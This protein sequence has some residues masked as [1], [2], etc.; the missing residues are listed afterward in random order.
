MENNLPDKIR[1][2]REKKGLN[3]S[4]LAHLVGVSPS[5]IGQ[6]EKGDNN[7]K[8]EV[9]LKLNKVL[10]YDFINDRPLN[11][12]N[13]HETEYRATV[14]KSVSV[15][16]Y[17]IEFDAGIL[18][19]LVEKGENN[20]PVGYLNIPEVSGCDAII[21]AKGDSMAPRIN[22]GDWV[23]VKRMLNWTDWL[24]VNYIYAIMTDDVELIKYI[25]KGS[26]DD[27]FKIVSDNPNYDDDEIPKKLIK[28]V[29][30]VKAILPFSR[31]ETII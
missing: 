12:L 19:N 2:Q 24:P 11:M 9:L 21:R 23:G 20:F 29:W 1:V 18:G 5:A 28:E 16:V 3:K 31:I 6:F 8:T 17:D 27:K 4:E 15:P 10:E 13:D 14:V 26:T 22:D 7:P 25:K 30:S